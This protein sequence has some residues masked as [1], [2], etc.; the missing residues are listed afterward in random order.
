M[1][2]FYI[3]IGMWT[4]SYIGQPELSVMLTCG[5]VSEA[6]S[7]L[8]EGGTEVVSGVAKRIATVFL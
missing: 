3:I 6:L 1:V 8:G 2:G 4:W 5:S 7:H